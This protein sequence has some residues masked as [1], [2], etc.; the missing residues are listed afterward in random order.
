[1]NIASAVAIYFIIWWMVLFIALPFGVRSSHESGTA[2]E[3]GHEAGAPV[4]PRLLWKAVMTTII[5]TIV[6]AVFYY[7]KTRGL[8]SI[9]NLPFFDSMPKPNG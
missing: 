4:D 2:V 1:M 3:E 6:F 7:A 9:E 8:L 5:A